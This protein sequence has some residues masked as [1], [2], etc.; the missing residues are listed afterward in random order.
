[1]SFDDALKCQYD[2][3][4]PVLKT[5]KLNAFFFVYTS[6]ITGNPDFLE[7]YR[8]FRTVEYDD[9]EDF[10]LE[11]FSMFKKR[12]KK[13]FLN[14]RKQFEQSNFLSEFKFYSESDKFFRFLRDNILSKQD[15]HI[16]MSELFKRKSFDF[17]SV[18]STLWMTSDEIKNLTQS[19]NILGLHS[20]NHPTQMHKL[21]KNEQVNEYK[22][23]LKYLKDLS[24]KEIVSMSH[25]CGN[26]N[27]DTLDLLSSM[28]ITIGFRSNS[29]VKKIK[30]SLEIPREDHSN[31][32]KEIYS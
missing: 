17:K 2:I 25:P 8:Y 11:F 7:V 5:N 15:Y 22:T 23:N 4:L 14:S 31:I 29:S 12:D 20:H 30:S 19:G 10:Y 13:I 1:M 9:I 28:G 26:Y 21:S 18:L 27:N 24:D 6:P 32:L 3:A 16:I